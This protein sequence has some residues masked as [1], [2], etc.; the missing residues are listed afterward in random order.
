MDFQYHYQ[1][2]G[3]DLLC[4][5]LIWFGHA[6]SPID[7]KYWLLKQHDLWSCELPFYD[8]AKSIVCVNKTLSD[9]LSIF[10]MYTVHTHSTIQF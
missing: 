8:W 3:L 4:L 7:T 5:V 1:I 6:S 10:V 9:R 2:T